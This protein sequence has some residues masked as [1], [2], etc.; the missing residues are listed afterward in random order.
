MMQLYYNRFQAE[1]QALCLVDQRADADIVH[2]GTGVILDI[3]KVDH[4]AGFC[5]H[6]FIDQRQRLPE[7][8]RV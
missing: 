8:S 4:A 6:L 5:L 2:P 7:L 1:I 3:G